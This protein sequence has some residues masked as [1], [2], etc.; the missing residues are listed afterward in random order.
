MLPRGSSEPAD[1]IHIYVPSIFNSSLSVLLRTFK[2]ACIVR[3][4]FDVSSWTE[5]RGKLSYFKIN[6]LDSNGKQFPIF[7]CSWEMVCQASTREPSLARSRTS[8]SLSRALSPPAYFFCIPHSAQP[9]LTFL[10]SHFFALAL[11][12]PP[13][14]C[15]ILGR[16][17]LIIC[18]WSKLPFL[19]LAKVN[20]GHTFKAEWM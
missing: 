13:S 11:S 8:P 7:L 14:L 2:E 18:V 1:T 3:L 9:P 16:D 5:M 20:Y 17:G 10:F 6:R 15:L 19:P 12:S 4:A